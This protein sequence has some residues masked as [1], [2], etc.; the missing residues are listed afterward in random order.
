MTFDDLIKKGYIMELTEEKFMSLVKAY[1]GIPKK[2]SCSVTLHPQTAEE[3]N[4]ISNTLHKERV[5]GISTRQFDGMTTLDYSYNN[6]DFKLVIFIPN[7]KE[8]N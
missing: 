6:S 3:F 5:E 8:V 2:F 4:L 7:R 1:E